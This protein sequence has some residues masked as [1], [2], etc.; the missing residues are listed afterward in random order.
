M[1]TLYIVRGMPGSGKSTFARELQA[2]TGALFV[3]P[4]MFLMS[5]GKYNYT[6]TEYPR[7]EE[8]AHKCLRVAVHGCA[9]LI[10][11][12]VLTRSASIE[13]L[14]S[15]TYTP[16]LVFYKMKVF[17]IKI[18]TEESKKRNVHNVQH[19]DIDRFAREWEDWPGETV[20]DGLVRNGTDG[21]KERRNENAQ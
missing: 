19:E 10:Y 8:R 21:T 4:D 12:D 17:T 7:A 6:I 13:Y 18:T 11:A 16:Q 14:Y 1:P 20:I 3:E 2:K 5:D 15:L 9:D